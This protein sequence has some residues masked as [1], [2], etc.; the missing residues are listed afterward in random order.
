MS[1]ITSS[2]ALPSRIGFA[3]AA[4]I[5]AF[6]AALTLPVSY[7]RNWL[8][9]QQPN[10]T[11]LLGGYAH[12]MILTQVVT[13]FM[14]YGGSSV[15]NHY[16]PKLQSASERGGFIVG[17]SGI[18]G[19]CIVLSI[20]VVVL[21]PQAPRFVFGDIQPSH[22]RLLLL[23]AV[24]A[25]IF[26]T[27][28]N[29]SVLGLGYFRAIAV[30]EM[31]FVFVPL[32]SLWMFS[33][34][35]GGLDSVAQLG[36][37]IVSWFVLSGLVLWF[38]F[39]RPHCKMFSKGV[40][41]PDGF[42]QFGGSIYLSTALSFFYQ[43]F[44]QILVSKYLSTAKLGEF[45]LV[46][47]ITQLVTFVPQKLSQFALHEFSRHR[48]LADIERTYRRAAV[49]SVWT[50]T[51]IAAIVIT[52]VP[53]LSILFGRAVTLEGEGGLIILAAGCSTG[54]LGALNS[55]LVL[56][57]GE[58]VVFTITN[59]VIIMTQATVNVWL[60]PLF[61]IQGAACGRVVAIVLGQIG[62]YRIVRGRIFNGLTIPQDYWWCQGAVWTMALVPSIGIFGRVAITIII[63]ALAIRQLAKTQA[64]DHLA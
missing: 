60:I 4:G 16:L 58:T 53:L 36:W 54:A 35:K 14:V 57:R 32:V 8:L 62:L 64:S 39:V 1:K 28:V 22:E 59:A 7:G 34:Q 43:Y 41:L 17:N 19:V 23:C 12:L 37:V 61:G 47:Q 51:T 30:Y 3:E 50:V 33:G 42:W 13:T 2:T 55:M 15:F 52:A 63:G 27:L 31:L 24:P 29:S 49:L 6:L 5:L 26:S 48:H 45:F 40:S 46:V 38:I 9:S 21:I 10:G 25:I 18:S 11:A 20:G 44:D 56:S